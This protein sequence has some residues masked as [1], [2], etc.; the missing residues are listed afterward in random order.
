MHTTAG[1]P[2]Y[3][4]LGSMFISVQIADAGLEVVGV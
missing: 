2:D 4:L 3:F 1:Q